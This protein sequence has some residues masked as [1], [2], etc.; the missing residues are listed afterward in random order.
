M[1]YYFFKKIKIKHV[2]I[3]MVIFIL[4]ILNIKKYNHQGNSAVYVWSSRDEEYYQINQQTIIESI[5]EIISP[6]RIIYS[7]T[8]TRIDA[9]ITFLK[10]EIPT[11]AY[12]T[13][14]E[15]KKP[16]DIIYK[17]GQENNIIQLK[18]D[19]RTENKKDKE[20]QIQPHQDKPNNSGSKRVIG[21][22]HTHTS[23]TYIDDPRNQ[24]S[25]GHVLPGN[26]G[27]V[28]KV[29]IELAKRLSET[30]NFEVIHTTKVHDESYSRSYLNSR[31]TVKEI[32]NNKSDID[33]L[34]D[35]HRDGL[36]R[37]YS[38]DAI[39]TMVNGQ[40]A[41]K[42]MI[43]VTNG[44]FD[45]AHLD[46]EDYHAEWE[47]NL[48]LAQKI[49]NQMEKMYPGLLSRIYI[50]NGTYNQDLH[51]RALLFEIGDY[52]NTTSEAIRSANLVANVIAAVL[53]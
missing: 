45:Y 8:K 17:Q 38:R 25:N 18:Y 9:P 42:V 1:M 28:G 5:K 29:G 7:I 16:T 41:A 13:P 34:L 14:D 49:K 2:I 50:K 23:E 12:Y 32:V 48:E 10:R 40:R 3:C 21:I 30:Y 26:I 31:Q 11:M 37:T 44:K 35:I 15:L 20:V 4:V 27:N 52:R 24:D 36:P 43:V 33:L 46:V 51:P 39:T 22:Y 53:N 19:L 47:K 6:E